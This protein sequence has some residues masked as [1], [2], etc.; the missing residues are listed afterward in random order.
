MSARRPPLQ[1]RPV[2]SATELSDSALAETWNLAQ[3]PWLARASLYLAVVMMLGGPS[4]LVTSSPE[5]T[6]PGGQMSAPFLSSLSP[7]PYKI[8][9]VTKLGPSYPSSKIDFSV[10]SDDGGQKVYAWLVVDYQTVDENTFLWKPIDPGTFDSN[11]RAAN[12]LRVGRPV[13]MPYTLPPKTPPGCHT[14][15]LVVT[16]DFAGPS[17]NTLDSYDST[18]ATWWLNVGDDPNS[19]KTLLS[20]CAQLV[21]PVQLEDAGADGTAGTT[22]E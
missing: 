8:I 15:T 12:G 6:Q 2:R 14:L 21:P 19:P 20:E 11:T 18:I 16:H 3:L 22:S 9:S 4:C 7:E 17:S 1:S 5:F 10:F 13:S